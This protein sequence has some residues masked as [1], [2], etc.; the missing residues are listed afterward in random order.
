MVFQ[1]MSSTCLNLS[2][3]LSCKA[4]F[5]YQIYLPPILRF[6]A[7]LSGFMAHQVLFSG[8]SIVWNYNVEK[9]FHSIIGVDFYAL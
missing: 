8:I 7:S 3:F 4:L 2:D 6:E 5:I 9:T 1:E